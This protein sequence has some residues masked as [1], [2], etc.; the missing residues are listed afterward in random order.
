MEELVVLPAAE[1]AL[2]DEDWIALDL[3]FDQNVDPLTGKHAPSA[4][5]EKLFTRIVSTAPA[6]IGLG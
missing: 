4:V 3:A 2:S 1:S 5:Y 6:P